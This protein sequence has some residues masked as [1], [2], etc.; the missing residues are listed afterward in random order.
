MSDTARPSR[1]R[2]PADA[3]RKKR[4]PLLV[5]L[6]LRLGAVLWLRHGIHRV[7]PVSVSTTAAK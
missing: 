3:V 1:Q 4:T 6:V 2:F 7:V 5:R